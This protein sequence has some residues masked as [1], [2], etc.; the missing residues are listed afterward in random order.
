MIVDYIT[1][2]EIPD[3]G[4]EANRQAVEQFLVEDRGFAKEDI[5]VSVPIK[6]TIAGEPYKS[7][8]DLVVSVDGVRFMAIKCAAGSLESREREILAAS[9]LFDDFQIPFSVV[10]DGKTT[11]IVLDTVTGKR[12]S[13]EMDAVFSKDEAKRK[14]EEIKLVAFPEDRREREKLIFRSYDDMNVNRNLD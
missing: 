4:A 2:N 11:A 7:R 10:S 14:L 13:R 12:L 5:K 1:G 3:I 9:R 6:M 8:I